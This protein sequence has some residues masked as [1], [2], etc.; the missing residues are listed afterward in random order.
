[1]RPF[2][3][4]VD[5]ATEEE[6]TTYNTNFKWCSDTTTPPAPP[7]TDEGLNEAETGVI[8]VVSLI[9]VAAVAGAVAVCRAGM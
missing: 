4:C 2:V 6:C 9:A 5:L 1:M 7:A 8:V 3:R